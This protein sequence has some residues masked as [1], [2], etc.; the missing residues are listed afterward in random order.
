MPGHRT[1]AERADIDPDPV[2]A[3]NVVDVDEL[4]RPGEPEVEH[5][6]Q[7]LATGE[8]LRV[9]AVLAQAVE[10]LR[11]AG[12]TGLPGDGSARRGCPVARRDVV[13]LDRH[14]GHVAVLPPARADDPLVH[15]ACTYGAEALGL[16]LLRSAA[17]GDLEVQRRQLVDDLTEPRWRSPGELVARARVLG[18]SFTARRYAAL[19]VT[20]LGAADPDAVSGR[21]WARWRRKRR[22]WRTWARMWWRWSVRRR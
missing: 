6:H 20:D 14:W 15:A 5:R 8:H 2:E 17:G 4:G 18:L 12:R 19:V 13:L 21:P 22:W 3:G 10:R 16:A 11:D 9:V 7:T 1:D